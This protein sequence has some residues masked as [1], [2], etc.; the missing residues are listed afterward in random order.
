MPQKET[1]D[2][3]AYTCILVSYR[4]LSPQF[5]FSLSGVT[6]VYRISM[7]LPSKGCVPSMYYRFLS[8]DHT[9][10]RSCAAVPE[11]FEMTVT[12]PGVLVQLQAL[13]VAQREE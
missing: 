8:G 9:V 10:S 5:Q 4:H 12:P 2:R 11:G 3:A 1:L 13:Q 7:C 6:L